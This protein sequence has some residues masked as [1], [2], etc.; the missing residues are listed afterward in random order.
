[1]SVTV[2][3]WE[4]GDVAP[5]VKVN[6]ATVALALALSPPVNTISGTAHDMVKED[7]DTYM[8][9]TNAGA[10][11]LTVQPDAT[12]PLDDNSQYHG[13]N[14]GAGD[15]T[16]AEG[17]GVTV[18]APAGGSLVVPQGGTFTLKRV[19]VNEFDLFGVTSP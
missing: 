10:K 9:F 19:A 2:D 8:R 15:L 11:T 12:E 18:N 3:E 16:I 7:A 4:E 13:R 1:M 14:V 5:W 6:E 17:S